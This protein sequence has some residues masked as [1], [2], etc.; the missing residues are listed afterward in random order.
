[1]I[2]NGVDLDQFRP[3]EVR[4]EIRGKYPLQG[5]K[6]VGLVSNLSRRK[7]PESL[8]EACPIILK[9][10]PSTVFVIVGGEFGEE[11][12]GREKALK[13]KAIEMGLDRSVIFTGFLPEVE[14]V[15]NLFDIAVAVTEKEACSR[16]ILEAMAC[17][18]PVVAFDTGGNS[19]LIVDGT[20]GALVPFGDISAFAHSLVG[21]LKD[22][23]RCKDMGRAA[24]SRAERCFDVKNNARKT[25]DLYA[26]LIG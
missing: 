25:E 26:R 24:R 5:K 16:A 11:D 8:L 20:T 15:I 12:R 23:A 13:R 19:E 2:L 9:R 18:K 21:L 7:M 22:D 3:K 17:A 10:C 14:E 6:V 4:P 1:V